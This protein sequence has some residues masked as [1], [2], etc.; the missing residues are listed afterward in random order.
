MGLCQEK[1]YSILIVVV[2]ILAKIA[3]LTNGKAV[4][5]MLTWTNNCHSPTQPQLE[6]EW[7]IIMSWQ[8]LAPAPVRHPPGT[9]K[10]LPGNIG[11]W[12]SVCNLILTQLERIPQ[13]KMEDNLKKNKKK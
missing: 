2:Y 3:K 4:N 12:F 5:N 13:K 7:D 10:A 9:F 11:S 6:L 1:Q 8:N